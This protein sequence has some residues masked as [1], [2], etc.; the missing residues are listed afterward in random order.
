M[1]TSL[2]IALCFVITANF[3]PTSPITAQDNYSEVQNIIS[4]YYGEWNDSSYP[5]LFTSRV[6]NTALMGNG[7]IGAASGGNDDSKSFY[8]SKGDFWTYRGSPV[9]IGGITIRQTK[10]SDDDLQSLALGA[11]ATASASH[12]NFP[13]S[14]MVSGNWSAGYEGWVSEVNKNAATNPFWAELDLGVEKTFNRIIIRHDA[15]ARPVETAN[16]TKDFSVSVRNNPSDSW[17]KILNITG[18]SK[19][20]TDE[21]FPKEIT[22]RYIRLEVTKGTQETTDDSRNNPR[23]RIGQFELYYS[24]NSGEIIPPDNEKKLHEIQDILN[25]EVRTEFVANEVK[26]DMR[27]FTSATENVMITELTSK[28]NEPVDLTVILWAKADDSRFPVSTSSNENTITITRSTP[29]SYSSN[30]NSHIS[31]AAMQSKIIGVDFQTESGKKTGE[32]SMYFTLQ[33][34][35]TVYIVT[36]V[37]GGGRTLSNTGALLTL[38]PVVQAAGIL[39]SIT[40]KNAALDLLSLHQEWWKNYWSKSYIKWDTGDSKLNSIMKYYYAA[41]YMLGSTIREGKVA[42]GLYGIWHTTDNP[43]WNSDFHLNY[44]FISTFYGASS[45]RM[46]Q[47]LPA[48]EAI[49]QY[50][51]QG[52]ANASNPTELRKVRSDFVNQKIA[53][54]DISSTTGISDAVLY[55]VG[56]GPWGMTLDAS[57]HNEALNASF[58]AYPFVEYYNYTID[59]DFL[60]NKMYNYLKLCVGFYEA[61]LEKENGKYILYAG[62]NEGSWAINPAVELSV[63]KSALKNLIMASEILGLD[64]DKR[65]FWQ[66]I[67]DN[68]APQPTAVYQGKTVFTLAEQEWVNE[69]WQPMSNPVPGDGNIIPME[70]VIP[71]EQLGYYSPQEQLD[72]AKNTID[73]FSVRGAWKQINNFPKIFPVAVNVR[74]P[75]QT[76]IDNFASTI[77]S[78][79]QKN[80]MIEDNVHGVEKAGAI[81]AV[82]NMMLLSD[83]GVIKVFPNWVSNRDA[84]FVGLREKGAFVLS[85]EYS[86]ENKE[87]LYVDLLSEAGRTV[88]IASPWQEGILV[89]DESG[90]KVDARSDK[91]PNHPDEITIR[92]NTQAGKTYRIVKSD[93]FPP[94]TKIDQ[95][96]INSTVHIYPNPALTGSTVYVDTG[97]F[98]GGMVDIYNITGFQIKQIPV[99][100]QIVPVKIDTSG[101]YIVALQGKNEIKKTVK[102]VIK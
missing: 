34:E 54:G 35:Q 23:A 73:I 50:V 86:A 88:T 1:K 21:I 91:A 89:T 62:Y 92:F 24:E 60:N 75:A 43:S 25:A 68:L 102:L 10:A 49:L 5:G 90:A 78:Q 6:P 101:I 81:E 59:N 3:L 27:T 22:A 39:S 38:D 13:V 58:S 63:L 82:N 57:Y 36:A 77:N 79:M 14:R 42:P 70:S 41:Q 40:D 30:A 56:I 15:A 44:N 61:W 98:N 2:Q 29:N 97:C 96:L 26:L 37:G 53:K 80:L 19:A 9:P 4:K 67:L 28:S 85:S 16:V 31:R 48:I 95:P 45:S 84:K 33:P 64:A 74:Y 66:E 47:N 71:G 94:A 32:S 72:I 52:K 100:E 69:K 99:L 12:P 8:I 18:N 83:Q 17:T 93:E 11:A 20:I 7:D 55:P 46:E 65:P 87:V 76:I 51:E